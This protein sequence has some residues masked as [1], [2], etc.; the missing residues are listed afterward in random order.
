MSGRVSEGVATFSSLFATIA[1]SASLDAP[2]LISLLSSKPSP[3]A[4]GVNFALGLVLGYRER[5]VSRL[6][7]HKCLLGTKEGSVTSAPRGIWPSGD[8]QEAGISALWGLTK[9]AAKPEGVWGLTGAPRRAGLRG[10]R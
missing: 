8:A 9:K 4:L 7:A 5:P 10:D 6:K 3:I 1:V 2:V